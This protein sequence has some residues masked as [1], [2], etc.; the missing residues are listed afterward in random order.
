MS[1]PW[2]QR[3]DALLISLAGVVPPDK[4]RAAF[5]KR[6]ASSVDHRIY[7]HH[8]ISY[9][10]GARSF[11]GLCKATGY[12]WRQVLRARDAL[13]Q[14]WV[15]GVPVRA[16]YAHNL[17]RGGTRYLISEEQ[18]DAIVAWLAAE[19]TEA[20]WSKRWLR[21]RKCRRTDSR[22]AGRGVCTR[23]KQ[24]GKP[25]ISTPCQNCGARPLSLARLL[26]RARA[27]NHY[28]RTKP[29]RQT[30]RSEATIA[31]LKRRGD[32]GRFAAK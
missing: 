28:A 7:E 31:R 18:G 26:A 23:C 15:R 13:K 12:D 5:P 4:V 27:R 17:G 9:R 32:R 21:C 8:G 19:K 6:T 30:E 20:R 14:T 2:T 25:G 1:R 22:H 24:R 10:R 16:S 11:H 29:P 3:E